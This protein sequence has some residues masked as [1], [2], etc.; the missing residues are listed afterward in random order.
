MMDLWS[1]I[2]YYMARLC[3][4]LREQRID[5]TFGSVRY[6]LQRDYFFTAGVSPDPGLL[7]FG[8]SIRNPSL[9]R[10]VK[11]VEYL[12]NLFVLGLRLWISQPGILHVEY[13]PFI[14][15]GFQFEIWFMKWAK[16]LGIPV[17]YTVHNVTYQGSPERNK[18]FYKRAYSTADALICHGQ[19]AR[20]QLS[21]EFGIASEKIWVIPHGPLFEEGAKL[22]PQEARHRLGLP[23]EQI[24]V[25]YFGVISEYKGISFL[26]DAWKKMVDAGGA[27]RLL[28]AGTGDTQLLA[29]IRQ[30]VVAKGLESSVSLRLEF[31]PV[32]QLPLFY[33]AADVLVFP[34]SEGTTSGA[35]LTGMNYGK[36]IVATHLPFFHEY[37][38]EGESALFV[39]YG[40][41]ARLAGTLTKLV[42]DPME[43]SRLGSGVAARTARFNSWNHIAQSTIECYEQVKQRSPVQE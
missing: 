25:L 11:S 8:G 12:F 19:D 17:V 31:I 42:A 10:I 15:H 21:Q 28:I 30:R 34:Y 27:G 23:V 32:E 38:S 5:V 1:F 13:L 22:S 14:D 7:D 18:R 33:Q 6:H 29:S 36:A 35:L 3:G 16:R 4:G 24:L 9:R 39:D 26:L 37:L 20:A 40:D 2:P 43:R 41:T